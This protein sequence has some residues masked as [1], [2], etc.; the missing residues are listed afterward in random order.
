LAK[1]FEYEAKRPEGEVVTGEVSAT[2]VEDAQ[3]LLENAKL[4]IISIRPKAASYLDW[5]GLAQ[6]VAVRDKAIF[7]RQLATMLSAGFPLLQALSVIVLQTP[8][9]RLRNII[10]TLI[11]DLEAGHAFSSSLNRFSDVFG[12]VFVNVV[13]SGEV[14][15]KLPQVLEEVATQIERDYE[16]ISKIRG[17]MYYPAFIIS[18]MIVIGGIMMVKVI[19]Q[20]KS[21]F[22][23]SNAQLP[24]TT[25]TVMGIS[26]FTA[27]YWWLILILIPAIYFGVRAYIQTEEGKLGW[28]SLKLNFP[29]IKKLTRLIYM[30]RFS[31]TFGLLVRTGIPIL[32]AIRITSDV[33][34]NKIYENSLK[35][36]YKQVEKG[37]PISVPLSRDPYFT[38][39]VVQMI[40]VG[41]QTGKLDDML[42][43]LSKFYTSESDNEL[44]NLTSLVEPVLIVIIG[45]AV[46][47]LV[48]SIIVPIYNIAQLQM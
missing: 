11:T 41:E 18:A 40:G 37:V 10:A 7:A 17:A 29:I 25:R 32:E 35:E 33:M 9:R 44:K 30:A 26:N 3:K 22:E 43:S 34:Q 4:S 8:N 5:L 15:G 20:L 23:E 21:I 27:H 39:M 6:R 28:D 42:G 46:G 31:S 12:P 2:T 47:F 19:P 48:F 14:T 36:V 16:F 13:R 38:P 24:W 1:I 45:I